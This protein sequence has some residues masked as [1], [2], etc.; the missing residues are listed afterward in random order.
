MEITAYH[1]SDASPYS[2]QIAELQGLTLNS[3][4]TEPLSYLLDL[5]CPLCHSTPP[6]CHPKLPTPQTNPRQI[7]GVR[8]IFQTTSSYGS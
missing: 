6:M 8:A 2:E 4:K 1:C 7:S 3:V 5:P